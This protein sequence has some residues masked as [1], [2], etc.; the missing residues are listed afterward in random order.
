MVTLGVDLASAAKRTAVCWIHWEQGRA[1][2]VRLDTRADD[3][4]LLDAITHVDKA[5]IDVPFGWP[6]DFIEAVAA[7]NASGL[8]LS[9]AP[10]PSTAPKQLQFRETD[11]FV[12]ARTGRWPLSVSS[13]R[14]AIPAM[15]A[16]VLLSQLKA[17]GQPVHREGLGK[18]VEVYPAAALRVWGF[19]AIG[20]KREQNRQ[21]RCDLLAAI[22]EKTSSW[23][24]T[25][26]TIRS[27]CE[28]TDDAVDALIGAIVAKAAA[29]ALCWEIPEQCVSKA[30]LEGWIALPTRRDLGV[31]P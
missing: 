3:D 2:V 21:A 8:W 30:R 13:D 4:A 29:A 27:L 24:T 10:H 1:E 12:Y 23:L 26:Q 20:Y 5:G 15:R 28:A 19:N 25:P 7:Y 22:L 31:S 14:I 17:S 6:Q 18:V 11:R 9:T 16:A